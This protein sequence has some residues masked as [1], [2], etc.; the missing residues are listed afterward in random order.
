LH[1]ADAVGIADPR[2][3]HGDDPEQRGRSAPATPAISLA[4]A[5]T[6]GTENGDAAATIAVVNRGRG[7]E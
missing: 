5:R 6:A 1:V 2:Q 7:L 4:A 3:E